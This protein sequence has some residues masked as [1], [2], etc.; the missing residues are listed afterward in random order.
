MASTEKPWSALKWRAALPC[1]L[2]FRRSLADI[3]FASRCAGARVQASTLGQSGRGASRFRGHCDLHKWLAGGSLWWGP[4]RTVFKAAPGA[5]IACYQVVSIKVPV[6][7]G[8]APPPALLAAIPRGAALLVALAR[9]VISLAALDR[10]R[11][12][13]RRGAIC[14]ACLGTLDQTA[15]NVAFGAAACRARLRRCMSWRY[16]SPGEG[17]SAACSAAW[18]RPLLCDRRWWPTTLTCSDRLVRR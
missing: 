9:V 8:Q 13:G 12:L 6:I 10:A 11:P 16:A 17:I 18:W 14:S 1:L 3:L 5:P 4:V 2:P 15:L 7:T